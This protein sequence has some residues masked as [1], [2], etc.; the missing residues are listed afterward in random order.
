M[1]HAKLA[2]SKKIGSRK[3]KELL[4][5]NFDINQ[6]EECDRTSCECGIYVAHNS[7]EGI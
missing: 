6:L 1:R 2:L 7:L 5:N 3:L 4:N